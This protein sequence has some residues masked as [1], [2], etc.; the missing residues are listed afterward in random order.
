MTLLGGAI[1][2][3]NHKDRYGSVRFI[4]VDRERQIRK[5]LKGIMREEYQE[6]KDEE[7]G[8]WEGIFGESGLCAAS[9]S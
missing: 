1:W 5:K 8:N 3:L 4:H 9:A 6:R 2:I 7:E